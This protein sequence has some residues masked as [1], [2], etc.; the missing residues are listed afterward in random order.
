MHLTA[1]NRSKLYLLGN[2]K[3]TKPHKTIAAN[4]SVPS[5]TVTKLA[6]AIRI[7]AM[8]ANMMPY[9]FPIVVANYS[10]CHTQTMYV[11]C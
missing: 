1:R 9:L 10:I 2:L 6:M 4:H 11:G 5:N 7:T 8:S 3:E